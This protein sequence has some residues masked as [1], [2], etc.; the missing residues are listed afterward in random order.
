[1]GK[2]FDFDEFNTKDTSLAHGTYCGLCARGV[3][4]LKHKFGRKKVMRAEKNFK[5]DFGSKPSSR[6]S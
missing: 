5:I 4:C 3:E 1:M 6:E 2:K